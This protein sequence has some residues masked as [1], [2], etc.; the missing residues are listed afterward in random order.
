MRIELREVEVAHRG[1]ARGPGARGPVDDQVAGPAAAAGEADRGRDAAGSGQLRGVDPVDHEVRGDVVD[2]DRVLGQVLDPAL[3][4]ERDLE[5]IRAV[6]GELAVGLPPVPPERPADG[7]VARRRLVHLDS[8]GDR[9]DQIALRIEHEDADFVRAVLQVEADR[10]EVPA[11][12]PIVG[13]RERSQHPLP[14][15]RRRGLQV[16]G[17]EERRDR[18]RDERDERGHRQPPQSAT[19]PTFGTSKSWNASRPR[20]LP[21]HSTTLI[22]PP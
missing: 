9:L 11:P 5:V 15:E 8:R 1:E 4:F 12:I 2:D 14:D 7:V 3:I 19:N 18:R 17:D 22:E 20:G 6:R 21:A 10:G 16:L 13:E